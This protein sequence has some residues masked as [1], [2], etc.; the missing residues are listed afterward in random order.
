MTRGLF[1]NGID[2]IE[3]VLGEVTLIGFG[4][5]PDGKKL[6]AQVAGAGFVEADVSDVLGI[7]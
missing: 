7:G 5:D 6:R 4:I 1:I 3:G 2:K